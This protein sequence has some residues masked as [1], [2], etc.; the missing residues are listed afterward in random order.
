MRGPEF[1][2]TDELAS[3]IEALLDSEI[4]GEIGW[5]FDRVWRARL[6]IRG[7]GIRPKRT[8]WCRSLRRRVGCATKRSKS[9]PTATLPR[10]T[11]VRIAAI[12]R[13]IRPEHP[14]APR[15]PAV[16]PRWRR[17]GSLYFNPE[18][19]GIFR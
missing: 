12:S 17:W 4:N 9:I 18:F 6:V 3:L 15:P 13:Y 14:D 8:G 5:F 2:L 19:G 10:N 7:M 16:E 11:C 1:E